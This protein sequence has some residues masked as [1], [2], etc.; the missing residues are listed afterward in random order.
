MGD[1]K[2]IRQKVRARAKRRRAFL[3]AFG[4]PETCIT[5]CGREVEAFWEAIHIQ[6]HGN[7][8]LPV[9]SGNLGMLLHHEATLK[10]MATEAAKAFRE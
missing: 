8:Q 1:L 10:R 6:W 5:S 4:I 7:Y 3:I 9:V 2:A